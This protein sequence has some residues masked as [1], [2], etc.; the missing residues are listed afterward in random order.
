[1]LSQLSD[2]RGAVIVVGERQIF[3]DRDALAWRLSTRVDLPNE[4]FG[5]VPFLHRDRVTGETYFVEGCASMEKFLSFRSNLR[6]FLEH[7]EEIDCSAR[8]PISG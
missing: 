6:L 2:T 3:I 8:H 1:M 5:D 7:V 4:E